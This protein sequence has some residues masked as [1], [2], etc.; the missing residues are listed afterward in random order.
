MVLGAALVLA[1]FVVVGLQSADEAEA[2][3]TDVDTHNDPAINT[4]SQ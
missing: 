3:L 2:S 1:S 4:I